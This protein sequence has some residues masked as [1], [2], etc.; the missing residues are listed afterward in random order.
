MKNATLETTYTAAAWTSYCDQKW[1]IQLIVTARRKAD[2]KIALAKGFGDKYSV[3][4][5]KAEAKALKAQYMAA[6]K[7][8]TK[9]MKANNI[10]SEG[11]RIIVG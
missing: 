10:P 5:F 2:N 6:T 1:A 8:L 3:I 11:D 4:E 7:A 9:F